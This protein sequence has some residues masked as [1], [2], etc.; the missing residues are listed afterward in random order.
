MP[1]NLSYW[2]DLVHLEVIS[3]EQFHFQCN[4]VLAIKGGC[5]QMATSC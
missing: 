5:F 4:V 2:H 3:F 1:L